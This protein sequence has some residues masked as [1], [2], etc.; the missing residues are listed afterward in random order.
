MIQRQFLALPNQ[1]AD[2]LNMEIVRRRLDWSLVTLD[3]AF[4]QN[5]WQN[6]PNQQQELWNILKKSVCCGE[7]RS[8]YIAILFLSLLYCSSSSYE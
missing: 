7:N 4:N 2:G 8:M 1:Q 5:T 3:T 6:Y